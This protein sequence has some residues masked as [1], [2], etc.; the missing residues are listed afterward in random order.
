MNVF[1]TELLLSLCALW[2]CERERESTSLQ[3]IS[4]RQVMVTG[5]FRTQDTFLFLTT[6]EL[7]KSVGIHTKVASL[8]MRTLFVFFR[9]ISLKSTTMTMN[10]HKLRVGKLLS[11]IKGDGMTTI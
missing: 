9:S 7:L 1:S 2:R 11:P 5:F 6:A 10:M 8:K 3:S 4:V